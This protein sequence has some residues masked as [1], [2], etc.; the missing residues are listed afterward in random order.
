MSILAVL[1]GR[2]QEERRHLDI[3][4]SGHPALLDIQHFWHPD[5]WQW[6]RHQKSQLGNCTGQSGSFS[7]WDK[8]PENMNK[9]A[10]MQ[11]GVLAG[12]QQCKNATT[13]ISVWIQESRKRNNTWTSSHP[14]ILKSGRHDIRKQDI[15]TSGHSDIKVHVYHKCYFVSHL[16]PEFHSHPIN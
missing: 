13:S 11:T 15:R 12:V 8:P 4:T 6:K 16:T 9:C 14:D 2:L 3:R 5:F 1:H 7:L 10:W